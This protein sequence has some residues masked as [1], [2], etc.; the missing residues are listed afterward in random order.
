MLFIV[1]CSLPT[2]LIL[3]HRW[4]ISVEC[5][6]HVF[7]SPAR[8]GA[9]RCGLRDRDWLGPVGLRT[10]YESQSVQRTF[11][12]YKAENKV[13][14]SLLHSQW[15]QWRRW[16]QVTPWRQPLRLVIGGKVQK[17]WVHC[18]SINTVA[19][20]WWLCWPLPSHPPVKSYK[21]ILAQACP[22]VPALSHPLKTI[23][24]MNLH[25][26][27]WTVTL[28]PF[29]DA[30]YTHYMGMRSKINCSLPWLVWLHG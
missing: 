4:M 2:E 5:L 25:D 21:S 10:L 14:K 9:R 7:S 11:P 30:H 12:E 8:D 17:G 20:T 26:I 23:I 18:P 27:Q 28:A 3:F 24:E 13:S 6:H 15:R 22:C 29:S 16:A 1:K 19:I